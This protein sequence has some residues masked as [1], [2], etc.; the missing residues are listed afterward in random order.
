MDEKK[1]NL[2]DIVNGEIEVVNII[3]LFTSFVFSLVTILIFEYHIIIQVMLIIVYNFTCNLIIRRR[4][5]VFMSQFSNENLDKIATPCHKNE[6]YREY[7]EYCNK[8]W[9]LREITRLYMNAADHELN[10]RCNTIKQQKVE[11]EEIKEKIK[12]K[13]S[14]YLNETI[15]KQKMQLQESVDRLR[16][17]DIEDSNISQKEYEE[18]LKNIAVLVDTL[19]KKPNGFCFVDTT[20]NVYVNEIIKLFKAYDV[21]SITTKEDREK[22]QEL[23]GAFNN[24]VLRTINKIQNQNQIEINVSCDVIIKNLN[25]TNV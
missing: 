17:F 21:K 7:L 5:H 18:I 9:V 13:G 6:T 16:N 3:D 2:Y 8:S 24:Y 1:A 4:S 11:K 14:I 20:F 15:S 12:E 19:D 23:M 25:K 10:I 22:I